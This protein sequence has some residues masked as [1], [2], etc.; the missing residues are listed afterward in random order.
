MI[1]RF[2]I[3]IL[4]TGAVVLLPPMLSSQAQANVTWT[5]RFFRSTNFTQEQVQS[6]PVTYTGMNGL[7]LEWNTNAPTRNNGSAIAGITSA[8]NFSVIFTAN[9]TLAAGTY[10]FTVE[11]DDGAKLTVGSQVVVDRL[12]ERG[13][14]TRTGTASITGGATAIELRFIEYTGNAIIKVSWTKTSGATPTPVP[15]STAAPTQIINT[16]IPPTITIVGSVVT[17]R[18]L[19]LR[20]GPYLGASL[21]GVLRPG[22]NYT[23]TARNDSEGIFTWYQVTAT[24]SGQTGW[25]SGRY[26]ELSTTTTGTCTLTQ[27]GVL[28]T[29]TTLNPALNTLATAGQCVNALI[30]AN[31]TAVNGVP[32][33]QS[34]VTVGT[35][36]TPLL[37]GSR[38]SAAL[39][40]YNLVAASCSSSTATTVNPQ[41]A[42]PTVGTVFTT[43]NGLPNT[44]VI[45]IPRAVMNIR[46]LPSTR[47][48]IVGQMPWGGEAQ[49]LA[50]TVQ[51]GKDFWYLV[52]YEDITGWIYA[53]YVGIRGQILDV[54]IY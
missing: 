8:D 1:K 51:G 24:D 38:V 18:G 29:L 49:L 33:A 10:T 9:P 52:R 12:N 48:R 43:L 17:V 28:N 32:T 2:F 13:R 20:S 3:L 16:P 40:V 54:P 7:I 23:V 14:V 45:A 27:Q 50:R 30:T 34:L 42:L 4:F 25:T 46:A 31:N 44:G 36:C 47:T 53:P 35:T 26:L 22:G 19:A 6:T 39:D 15:G 5:A 11:S 41:N 21:V 37:V